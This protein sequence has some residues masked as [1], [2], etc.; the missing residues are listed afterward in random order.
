MYDIFN[1]RNQCERLNF[2]IFPSE[3]VLFFSS[4]LAAKIEF[5][6]GGVLLLL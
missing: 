2:I 3:F 1:P 5:Y 6:R 4:E